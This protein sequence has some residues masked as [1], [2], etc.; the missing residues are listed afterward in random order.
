MRKLTLP[1]P[2]RHA[3]P[4]FLAAQGSDWLISGWGTS[5]AGAKQDGMGGQLPPVLQMGRVRYLDTQSCA[6][7]ADYALDNATMIW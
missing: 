3:P 2:R 1:S 6:G 5:G 7:L 4:E